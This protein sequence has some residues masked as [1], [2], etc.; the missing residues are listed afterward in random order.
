MNPL[1]PPPA[2]SDVGD[3][4]AHEWFLSNTSTYQ[5]APAPGAFPSAWQSQ[6]RRGVT[7]VS[8][9]MNL[10][11]G[12]RLDGPLLHSSKNLTATVSSKRAINTKTGK[13]KWRNT[14]KPSKSNNQPPKARQGT[15]G[16][17]CTGSRTKRRNG[18]RTTSEEAHEER[19]EG[20]RCA[21]PLEK[22]GLSAP[23]VMCLAY[24]LCV[25]VP[26]VLE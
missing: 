6:R 11:A 23:R 12:K 1:V 2:C 16:K 18:E 5:A 7:Q 14:K 3:M 17:Q 26:R 4:W 24:H 9:E 25:R 19:R 13:N 10:H 15:E 8:R 21:G 20:T 22:S